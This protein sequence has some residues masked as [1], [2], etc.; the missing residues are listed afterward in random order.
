MLFPT[1]CDLWWHNPCTAQICRFDFHVLRL[2]L[3]ACT[4][5]AARHLIG[6][7]ELHD[8]LNS[9]WENYFAGGD[10]DL[11]SGISSN[12]LCLE[13]KSSS[14]YLDE[15][16]NFGEL[17]QIAAFNEWK[18]FVQ[19]LRFTFSKSPHNFQPAMADFYVTYGSAYSR[20]MLHHEDRIFENPLRNRCAQLRELTRLSI[21]VSVLNHTDENCASQSEASLAVLFRE[22]GLPALLVSY[23]E[24]R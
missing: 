18:E 3:L 17:S 5:A 13:G 21:W 1:V 8:N 7:I 15:R 6:T 11:S 24:F 20:S 23:L 10:S 12:P 14:T 4:S 22:L 9:R 19:T 16:G 2:I